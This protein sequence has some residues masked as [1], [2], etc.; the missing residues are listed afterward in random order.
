MQTKK[1]NVQ[2]QTNYLKHVIR[3]TVFMVFA[4][5]LTSCSGGSGKEQKPK[6]K[7]TASNT[8]QEDEYV[9]QASFQTLDNNLNNVSASC[10]KDGILYI[11]GMQ[12][13]QKKDGSYET[14]NILQSCKPDG[15][16]SQQIKLSIDKNAYIESFGLDQE[17]NF[18]AMARTYTYNEKTGAERNSLMLYSFD[19]DGNILN[20][21]KIKA[22]E[23]QGTSV[24]IPSNGVIMTSDG[25]YIA[26]DQTVY[27]L[28]QKGEVSI[29][30]AFGGYVQGLVQ[31]EDGAIYA[32]GYDNNS[33]K[34]VLKQLDTTTKSFTQTI[35][36]TGGISGNMRLG[37]D[38]NIYIDDQSNMYLYDT[39]SQKA[40]LLLSW[41]NCDINGNN[42]VGCFPMEDGT[43]LAVSS[44][45]NSDSN[46]IE[47]IS[48]KKVKASEVPEK[49]ILT[50]A[51]LYIDSFV[52]NKILTFNRTNKDYRIQVK[53]YSNYEDAQNQ[54]SLDITSG[55]SPDIIDNNL[56]SST[57][58]VRKG[59]LTDLYPLMEQDSEIKK[60]D[61]L[62]SVIKSMERDGKLYSMGSHFMV[63][64]LIGNKKQMKDTEGWTFDDVKKLYETMP[65]DGVFM[66]NAT[67][68]WFLQSIMKGGH[69]KQ[70][71]DW[72]SKKVNFESENFINLLEFSKNF[73]DEKDIE[74]DDLYD[75]M[76]VSDDVEEGAKDVSY[77]GG[78]DSLPMLIK[79]G[80][81]M[82]NEV[83][84]SE[85][86]NIEEYTKL[87]KSCGG[88]T[89]LSYPSTDGNNLLP[90][91]PG[92]AWM[93]IM[94]SCEDK[95]G[96]W[97]FIR[98]FLTYDYQKQ[99]Y[100]LPTRKDVFEK[101]LEYATATEPYTDE[102]GTEVTPL[103]LT[104]GYADY[105]VNLG[106]LTED[107]VSVIRSV[108]DRMG[109]LLDDDSRDTDIYQIITEE[110]KGYFSGDK[111]A[112]ETAKVI[113]NRAS[114]YVSE[115]S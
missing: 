22:K 104:Y 55:S 103:H 21:T 20:E 46:T 33:D 101:K 13:K 93:S 50:F 102:D 110:A 35:E 58:Y 4:L 1:E 52:T 6:E 113:Q 82:L 53:D 2:R 79:K 24:Y 41:I 83:Y 18:Y 114:I 107:E 59:L 115:N 43:I 100:G 108:I 62:D 15:S 31:T 95:E 77:T 39:E 57:E 45:H 70:Y 36:L 25:A 14:K 60:E 37:E 61:F 84:M 26:T 7:K 86:E 51:C 5:I 94:E 89:I 71:V 97:Q 34:Y 56:I 73:P 66:K 65:K 23:L 49:T 106:P 88:F 72:D 76:Y 109:T 74:E 17:K 27:L 9:Y 40:T 19:T 90:M 68:Q 48:L 54:L 99:D 87:Y 92:G 80:K 64:F 8:T 16:D 81:L 3:V 32:S 38:G 91:F 11:L 42:L 111:T 28:N 112:E 96:A 67:R 78:K 47:C 44:S 63:S 29:A 105:T 98:E 75:S 30:C 12:F 10:V 69:M 85:F